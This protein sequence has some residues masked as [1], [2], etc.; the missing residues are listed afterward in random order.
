MP[1]LLRISK[2]DY[3]RTPSKGLYERIRKQIESIPRDITLVDRS[4]SLHWIDISYN[5]RFLVRLGV[6]GKMTGGRKIG[7][8][9][10]WY[11]RNPL[12]IKLLTPEKIVW[13]A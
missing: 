8:N 13:F 3:T 5:A 2:M 9:V 7:G 1:T 12:T 11:E 10:L 6:K 4:R